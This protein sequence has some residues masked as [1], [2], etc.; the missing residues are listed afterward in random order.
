MDNLTISALSEE[1]RRIQY[2]ADVAQENAEIL[3]RGEKPMDPNTRG[4][5]ER[6]NT[7]Q[8]N[9]HESL[10]PFSDNLITLMLIVASDLTEAKRETYEFPFSQKNEYHSVFL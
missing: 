5:Q 3:T 10:F 4:N 2:L 9:N 6:W 7:A 1:Q 8:V